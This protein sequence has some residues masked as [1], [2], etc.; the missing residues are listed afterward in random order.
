MKKPLVSV[1]TCVYNRAD[2]IHRVFSS[3][4]SQTYS[5]IEHIIIDDGSTDNLIEVVD[6]YMRT[7]KYPVV[8]KSK[9]NGGKH[10]ATNMAWDLAKGD[11]ILQ[12][13]SDDEILPHAVE[14]L[15][16]LWNEIPDE[17]IGDYWCVHG[18]CKTQH[19]DKMVGDPYPEGINDLPFKQS[20]ALARCCKGDKVGLMKAKI[21]NEGRYRYPEPEHVKFVT[22][23]VLWKQLNKKYRTYYSNEIVLVY[24]VNEG[25]CLSHPTK[26]PQT[27]NNLCWN[28]RWMIAHRKEYSCNLM[29]SIALYAIGYVFGTSK[30]KS[31]WNF[32]C[33]TFKED[34]WAFCLLPIFY[35]GVLVCKPLIKR[36][37][38]IVD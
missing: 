3:I 15:V 1:F 34:F 8:F 31:K 38:H 11:Y 18:R 20:Y 27:M 22:E 6:E 16:G 26:T 2:K 9:T 25:E 17:F 21:L 23:S 35:I 7:A 12:L 10:T 30:F 24:Y 5:N 37:L 28:Q 32:F 29:K 14:Y 13:D 33:V 19:C 4:N 36:K